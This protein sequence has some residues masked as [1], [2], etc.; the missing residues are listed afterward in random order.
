MYMYLK[1]YYRVKE[2]FLNRIKSLRLKYTK[3]DFKKKKR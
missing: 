2:D 1:T 3:K